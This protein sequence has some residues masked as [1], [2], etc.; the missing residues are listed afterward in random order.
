MYM[1]V[2]M[3]LYIHMHTHTHTPGSPLVE[4]V[5]TPVKEGDREREK[6]RKGVR[7]RREKAC[8]HELACACVR[9]IHL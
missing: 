4:A 7:K 1:F 6:E 2:C 8:A 5:H 9:A 3:H